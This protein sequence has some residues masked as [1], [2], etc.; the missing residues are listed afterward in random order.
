[1]RRRETVVLIINQTNTYLYHN[2][3][4]MDNSNPWLL[5][6]ALQECCAN[7][8]RQ[9]FCQ[10]EQ[11]LDYHRYL[12]YKRK[13]AVIFH[14]FFSSS[15]RYFCK[16]I[17]FLYVFHSPLYTKVEKR[18]ISKCTLVIGRLAPSTEISQKTQATIWFITGYLEYPN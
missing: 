17:N 8:G 11:L 15:R 2:R 13:Q 12:K 1:M 4:C 18:S 5:L 6:A 3:F 7:G 9:K 14:L 16:F 10:L